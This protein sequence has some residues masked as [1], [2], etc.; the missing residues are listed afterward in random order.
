MFPSV[1][2]VAICVEETEDEDADFLGEAK[3][4]LRRYSG[5]FAR[6]RT[7]GKKGSWVAERGRG[8]L[9]PYPGF[10]RMGEG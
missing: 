3:K 2:R 8:R 5:P 7:W 1:A 9:L 4:G 6:P 10:F